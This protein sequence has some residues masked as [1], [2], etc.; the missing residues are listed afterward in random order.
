[1][2]EVAPEIVFESEL[3]NEAIKE[4]CADIAIL[5]MDLA[6]RLQFSLEEEV[7]KNMVKNKARKWSKANE[8]GFVEHDVDGEI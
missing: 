3:N 2:D 1:M 6:R 7:R 4:E 8:L 5:I